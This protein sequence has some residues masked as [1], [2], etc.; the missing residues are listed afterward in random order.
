MY[1]GTLAECQQRFYYFYLLVVIVGFAR[2]VGATP[3]IARYRGRVGLVG[4]VMYDSVA[5]LVRWKQT[6]MQWDLPFW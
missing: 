4:F 1:H 2:L 3:I 5:N 6:R